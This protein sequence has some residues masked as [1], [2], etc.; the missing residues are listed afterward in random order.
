M[1]ISWTQ[2]KTL[3]VS[4]QTSIQFVEETTRYLVFLFDSGYSNF[5]QIDKTDPVNTDQTDFEDNFKDESNKT[6]VS[7]TRE[8]IEKNILQAEL[9]VTSSAAVEV[10]V[11]ASRLSTRRG[12]FITPLVNNL[13]WGSSSV[14][15]S[16]GT[17]LFKNATVFIAAGDVGLYLATDQGGTLKARIKEVE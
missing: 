11:G 7:R 15:A 4:K 6:L 1:Q 8:A 17:P 2:L 9:S 3:S 10:K 5:C 14:T 13:Y 16:N 12:V